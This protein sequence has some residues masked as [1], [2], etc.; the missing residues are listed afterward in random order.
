MVG[1]GKMIYVQQEKLF[2][3]D[4]TTPNNLPQ[5]VDICSYI[6]GM[7]PAVSIAKG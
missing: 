3:T 4:C 5:I 7:I 1:R 6:F 2:I